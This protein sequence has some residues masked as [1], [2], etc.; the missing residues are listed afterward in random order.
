MRLRDVLSAEFTGTLLL[1]LL[2]TGSDVMADRLTGGNAYLTLL[3]NSLVTGFGISSLVLALNPVSGSYF[4]PAVVLLMCYQGET[5]WKHAPHYIGMQLTGALVGILLMHGLFGRALLE[6]A[7]KSYAGPA[8]AASELVATFG[9]LL[10]IHRVGET[11][12]Q[13]VAYAVGAYLVAA[14][15]FAP[16]HAFAN[17]AITVARMFTDTVAGIRPADVPGFLA[18]QFLAVG[19]LIAVL[20]LAKRFGAWGD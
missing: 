12:S 3:A 9:L 20:R 1:T 5:K 11:R 4:N 13:A 10:V 8:L 15:W 18:A 17:P 16:S 7:T 2:V 19:A 6:L 14:S